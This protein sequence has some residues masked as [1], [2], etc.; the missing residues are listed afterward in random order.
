MTSWLG[1]RAVPM[2]DVPEV[3]ANKARSL[4]AGSWLAGLGAMVAG[5]ARDW[6]LSVGEPYPDST[7][8]WVARVTDRSGRP[9]V[10][11]VCLPRPGDDPLAEAR[12]EAAVLER[13]GGRGC[14][15]LYRIDPTRGALLVERLG[16]SLADLE[17]PDRERQE[18]LSGL[19]AALWSSPEGLDLPTGATK[20]AWLARFIEAT[21]EELGRPCSRAAVDQALAAA[22]RRGAA[23]DHHR[24]VLVHGDIHPWNTLQVLS[25]DPAHDRS[26]WKLIDPDGL[27]AEPEYD[28]GV[29]LREDP[30]ELLV[31]IDAGDPQRR[32]RWL[33][34]RTGTDVTAI[35][36][37]GL[38]ERVSTGL[39]CVRVGLQPVGTQML[40]AADRLAGLA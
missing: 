12:R 16:P 29:L 32:A 7:E 35:W 9:A 11:K 13:A 17:R 36:E 3:V 14:A 5:L 40:E 38:A 23:H 33:A 8:G 20:A 6:E 10:L 22:A 21:W 26:S 18:I 34:D 15:E 28:L 37:W 30:D 31:D 25:E 27:I 39:L 1:V 4:G 2:I 24:A 19:A